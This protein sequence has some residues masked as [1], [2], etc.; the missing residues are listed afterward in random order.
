MPDAVRL[1]T[2]MSAWCP[3]TRHYEVPGGYLA[4][5][6]ARFGT[7]TGT[8]MFLAAENGG[9]LSLTPLAEHP[10]G[11]AHTAALEAHGYTV[12]D[13][14]GDEPLPPPLTEEESVAGITHA[15]QS[16]GIDGLLPPQ[17]AAMIN[18]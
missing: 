9:A 13:T 2:D 4:V 7:A 11:T 18:D 5:T 14:I 10:E 12:V 8:R 6:A 15:L 16:A 3:I 17:I 1:D